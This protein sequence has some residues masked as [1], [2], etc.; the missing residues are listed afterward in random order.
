VEHNSLQLQLEEVFLATKRS[1][2]N[3]KIQAADFLVS[4]N[5]KTLPN[6]RQVVGCLGTNRTKAK[7]H[8][9]LAATNNRLSL[10]PEE[11][12]LGAQVNLQ[13]LLEVA[14]FL[15]VHQIPRLNSPNRRLGKQLFLA[16]SLVKLNLSSN[17]LKEV[18][19]LEINKLLVVFLDNNNHKANN[20]KIVG[21]FHNN[22]KC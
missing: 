1:L 17:P 19:S 18:D 5:N 12:Y 9:S 10:P 2:N 8:L 11:D 4:S 20:N 13:R 15:A 22:N 14:V 3:S 16:A 21:N 6:L 7:H